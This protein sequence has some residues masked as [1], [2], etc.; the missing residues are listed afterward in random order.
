MQNTI[1]FKLIV[2]IASTLL[3]SIGMIHVTGCSSQSHQPEQAE[4]ST[5]TETATLA[6]SATKIVSHQALPTATVSP[7]VPMTATMQVTLSHHVPTKLVKPDE[8]KRIAYNR[9]N[10]DVGD[11]ANMVFYNSE[12]D[13]IPIVM[14][15][16]IRDV[17]PDEDELGY[18]LSVSPE[19]F[20]DHLL[21]L[22]DNDYYTLR[23]DKLTACLHGEE[24][25]PQKAVALTFDDG[26][27]DV[28]TTV[29]PLLK[30][31]G[32]TATFYIVIDFVGKP[33]YLS[34]EQIK[35]V[36]DSGM[37]IG[38]HSISH[39]DLTAR[40]Y[41]VA[42]EEIAQSRS[43]LEE[44]LGISVESFCYPIGNYNA[45]VVEMV[46]DVGYTNAVTTY[47]GSSL[48]SIF[49]LPRLRMLGGETV[50]AFEWYITTFGPEKTPTPTIPRTP[51]A[52]GT[53]EENDLNVRTGAGTNYS[54]QSS[55]TLEQGDTVDILSE[56]SGKGCNSWFEIQVTDGTRGWVCAQF[57]AEEQ[58]AMQAEDATP[59]NAT[60]TATGTSAS[61]ATP[62]SSPVGDST[63]TTAT[64]TL[65]VTPTPDATSTESPTAEATAL[66]IG[67]VQES[68]LNV[69]EG[70][71]TDYPVMDLEWVLEKGDTVKILD[72]ADGEGCDTWV[73]IRMDDN[74][75]GWVCGIYMR[76][77]SGQSEDRSSPTPE[78][79]AE[80]MSL[81]SNPDIRFAVIGDY[82][83]AGVLEEDVADLV[84]SWDPDFIVT[85]GDN[86]YPFGAAE[87]IDENIGQYYHEYIYPY[88]GIY[89][90]GSPNKTNR[91]YPVLGNHDLDSDA[92]QPYYDYFTLPG[93][94][95]YYSFV[96]GP[97]AFFAL[98]S[99]PG[100]PDG[101]DSE[102]IQAEWLRQ[103]LTA[104][105]AC[106]NL[107]IFHHPPYVS[108]ARGNNLWMSWPFDA[109]GADA[110]LSGHHHVYER[111]IY[112]GFPYFIN[113]LG[114]G[115]RYAFSD[116]AV[117]G[118]EM[119]YNID[120]GA[121]LVEAT[122]NQIVFQF[123]SRTNEVVDTYSL[124]KPC[125][126]A[127]SWWGLSYRAWIR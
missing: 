77:K 76:Q 13:Y 63:P 48:A 78:S 71:G 20:E 117:E 67:V 17:D 57:V 44:R 119:R 68:H 85:T 104:S 94:E 116:E 123:V 59:R 86:N 81:L 9:D 46:R 124:E 42:Y 65:I 107:V 118:S 11:D 111:I 32:F 83:L 114:G 34:W 8:G 43:T 82:G 29:L 2:G 33:G 88:K 91:F 115:A 108:D 103:K 113:G 70:P 51:I 58:Q 39:P 97:V 47:P 101:I 106:W 21:W 26:Y 5:A 28:A 87:T 92:A 98:N 95:R 6:P 74:E 24:R 22:R 49:E 53:I 61:F 10:D 52:I 40:E 110:A 4:Q 14:Y 84:K 102:S 90:E 56:A 120:N 16:Y 89:G 126:S 125:S 73:Q 72:Q 18:N 27:E 36:H 79:Q 99:M 109:W 38:A 60:I 93:N 80:T 100:E 66:P 3:F 7:S 15:H 37:E 64:P 112:D 45:D 50:E 35:E 19:T 55:I 122:E 69:R 96:K 127:P 23:M 1:F 54:I 31:Y 41:A 121:M 25:C 62:T 75:E 105:D 30:R 12:T